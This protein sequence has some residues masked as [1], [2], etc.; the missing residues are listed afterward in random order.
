MGVSEGEE[1]KKGLERLFEE[2]GLLTSQTLWKI[3]IYITKK[4][5]ELQVE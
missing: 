2:T 4:L 3:L 1:R 5:N